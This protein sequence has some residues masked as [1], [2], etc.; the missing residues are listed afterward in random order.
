MENEL[1]I[2]AQT[3][4]PPEAHMIIG[5]LAE[6]GVEAFIG[7]EQMVGVLPSISPM[8]GGVKVRVR[9]QDYELALKILNAPLEE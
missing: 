9:A 3:M 8:A 2:V 7:D 5:V 6:N 4:F 1:V